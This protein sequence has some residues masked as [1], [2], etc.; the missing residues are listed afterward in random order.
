MN[1]TKASTVNFRFWFERQVRNARR[2]KV[3][4]G[5]AENW[6]YYRKMLGKSGAEGRS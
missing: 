2:P 4:S 6:F 5:S 3:A 1:N